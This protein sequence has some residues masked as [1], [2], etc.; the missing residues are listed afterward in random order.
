MINRTSKSPRGEYCQ[1]QRQ[2]VEESI[3]LLASYPELKALTVDL[4]YLDPEGIIRTREVKYR[5][6]LEHAKAVFLFACPSTECVGGD[7][8]LSA[9]LAQRCGG[10]AQS[11]NRGNALPGPVQEGFQ[12]GCAV[13][14]CSAVYPEPGVF[15]EA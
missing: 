11:C 14:K 13:P 7:F 6:N 10:P 1:H 9:E 4:E 5:V 15:G 2:R 3:P 12:W 8:D